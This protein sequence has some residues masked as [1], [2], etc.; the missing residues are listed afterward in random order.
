M[1]N[2]LRRISSNLLRTLR[3]VKEQWRVSIHDLQITYPSLIEFW[4][5][6]VELSVF[7]VIKPGVAV[8]FSFFEARN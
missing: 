2:E 5:Y 6:V 4:I 8:F 3:F 1:S 7:L